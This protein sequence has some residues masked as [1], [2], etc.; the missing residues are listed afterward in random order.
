MTTHFEPD[1]VGHDISRCYG[2]YPQNGHYYAEDVRVFYPADSNV[3]NIVSCPIFERGRCGLGSRLSELTSEE[4]QN[5]PPC[6][7]LNEKFS[8]RPESGS[9]LSRI[10]GYQ[11][12]ID[13][14][15]Y[16]GSPYHW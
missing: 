4:I 7:R 13:D 15:N 14:P 1:G 3:P 2:N 8:A 6:I 5:L 12:A 16:V 11:R 10:F 9:V